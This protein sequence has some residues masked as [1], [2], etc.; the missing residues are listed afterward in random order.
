[1]TV[2]VSDRSDFTLD[3]TRRVAF[4]RENA[5]FSRAALARMARAHA[6]FQ[7]Y[8]ENNR[9]TFIYGVTTLGGA[10]AKNQRTPEETLRIRR[11]LRR[12][13]LA[14]APDRLPE[15]AVRA[16]V[17][18][19]LAQFIEGNTATHP[20]RAQAVAALLE[21]PLASVPAQGTTV[22]G[23]ILAIAHLYT[24]V[25]QPEH[26]GYQVG[27]LNGCQFTT[28]LA[29]V[30]AIESRRR[31]EVTIDT[32][33]LAAEAFAVP[34]A[35][36]DPML[37]RHWADRYEQEAIIAL[38]GRLLGARRDGRRPF[39]APVSFGILP[40]VLGQAHRAVAALED[41]AAISLRAISANPTYSLPDRRHPLGHTF[42]NAGYH[43]AN[44]P[45][46]MDNVAACWVDLAQLA[47]R[48]ASKLHKGESSLLPDRLYPPGS[49]PAERVSTSGLDF[50][51]NGF[52]EEMRLLAQPSLL[53]SAEPGADEQD[54]IS[55]PGFLAYRKLGRV[56]ELLDATLAVTAASASQALHLT[57]RPAPR[58]LRRFLAG[59]RSHFP[60]VTERR[61]LGG[62]A[63]AL[64]HWFAQTAADTAK[65]RAAAS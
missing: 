7:V 60:P 45:P 53:S 32:L 31:L 35:E 8:V 40:R 44:C 55:A 59:V 15:R 41:V 58:G 57:G 17:F 49:S 61:D 13:R 30:M 11:S 56:S 62:D 21:R 46:A 12:P 16:T 9:D 20:E 29:A 1:M 18:A 33:A 24:D 64:A 10:E 25:P 34:L 38:N 39:E 27:S 2:V 43:N 65:P 47:H 6:L 5:R 23:E 14:F 22:P 37:S 42:S 52:I 36:Y 26:A 50:V 63:Q 28:G 3:N 4:R 54:D 51:P 19:T 48:H